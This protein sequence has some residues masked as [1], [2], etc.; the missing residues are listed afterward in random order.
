M[1]KNDAVKQYVY[2]GALSSLCD[3]FV[4]EKRALGFKFNKGAQVLSAFSRFTQ[5][6]E[7]PENTLTVEVVNAWITRRPTETKDNQFK[8]FYLVRQFAEYMARLGYAAYIP[9]QD[10]I[11]RF[12]KTFIP[13]I[14]SH[15]EIKRFFTEV[16]NLKYNL[17]SGAPRR[18]LVMPVIFRIL[19]CCGLRV[20]EA[21]RLTGEDVD[22]KAGVLTVLDSK[23]SKSRYIPMSGELTDVCRNYGKTRLVAPI[24][25]D[26]WFFAAP[27]GGRYSEREIY[28]VFRE[29]L[30]K[31]GISHG[32]KGNGP[33]LH[34]IRH[35]FAVHCLQKWVASG[36]ELTTAIP[37]L[38]AY[39]GHDGFASTEQYLR[40]TAEVHP[41]IS[42]LMQRQFG[43]IIPS[44]GVVWDEND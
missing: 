33:R 31:A 32:G 7:L 15:D 40:M 28:H 35:T 11:G 36:A 44:E 26:D 42:E 20:S 1:I 25:V 2:S 22:L 24:G 14:F 39:L 4:A 41:E 23:F 6:F 19:Y 12:H 38:S 34:D 16:D 43:Y 3:S 9:L 37:R 21:A 13:Y 10:E 29:V 17:R 30:W 27:D 18:H 5:S 8:R